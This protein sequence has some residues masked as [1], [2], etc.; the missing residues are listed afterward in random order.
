M[1][2][3]SFDPHRV[4]A[5]VVRVRRR[6]NDRRLTAPLK[7]RPVHQDRL[8]PSP[9]FLLS[10]VRSGSTLLRV[11][12]DSHS[13]IHAPH[14][15]HLGSLRVT[16]D[17]WYGQSAIKALDLAPR[18][19][20]NLLWDRVLHLELSK[21]Q[22]SVLVDKTPYNTILWRRIND[23]WPQARYIFLERHPL[24]IFES[25]ATSRPDVDVAEHYDN[26]NKYTQALA[27]ARAALPGPTV[28]YEDLTA[29]PERVVRALCEY[30]DV[31]FE[32][33]MLDYGRFQH[34][35]LRRGLGDWGRNINSGTIKPPRPDPEPSEIPEELRRSCEQIGYL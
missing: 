3:R 2:A 22:K 29:D 26:V 30:L 33:E 6:L 27:R 11:I 7:M 32:P 24:R 5:A 21:A 34:G 13:E 19:L 20:E 12:L 9:V 31:D 4:R 1:A 8:V 35:N 18:D 14:E 28:R 25:L 10:S 15:M 16:P 23:S 17:G